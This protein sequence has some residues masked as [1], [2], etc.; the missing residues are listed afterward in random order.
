MNKLNFYKSPGC[1]LLWAEGFSCS[2]DVLYR[3]LG[4]SKLQFLI[5]KDNIFSCCIFFN[6]LELEQDS[7]DILD[8]DSINTDPQ[9][10]FVVL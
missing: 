4:I 7:L 2:M 6:F 5:K 8:P 9:H 1:S 10:C 3:D